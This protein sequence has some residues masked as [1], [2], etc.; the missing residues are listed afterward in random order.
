MQQFLDEFPYDDTEDQAEVT[1]EM[2]RD[3]A[4]ERPMDRLLCGDVGFGKTE[5]AVRA[6][7]RVVSGGGQV[8]V[9]VPTTI[10]AEQHLATFRSRMADF[11]MTVRGLSRYTTPKA[12][13]KQTLEGLVDGHVDVVIGT[14][15]ILSKDVEFKKLGLVIIDEE[16]RFGVT[17]KEHFKKLRAAVDMLTLTATPIPRRCTCRCR[18]SATSRRST[19]RRGRQEIET[20]LGYREDDGEVQAGDPQR[21][22]PRGQIFYLHNRVTS[23]EAVANEICGR[24][25]PRHATPSATARCPPPSCGRS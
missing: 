25:S 24:S 10:L 12:E 20:K 23:I 6:A 13:R 15:R 8:A 2:A 21:A 9:L 14:H 19:R 18:A 5:L 4:S 22:Q 7:F 16:Q 11:P 17:H 3:L 1:T